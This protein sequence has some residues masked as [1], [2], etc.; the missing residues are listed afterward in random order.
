MF[1]NYLRVAL[2][3]LRRQRGYSFINVAGLTVGLACCLV[4]FQYVAFETSYDRFH[5]HEEDL[6]RVTMS[7][8]R[9]DVELG[10]GAT[11]TA[12]ATGPALAEAI[13]E[14]A[15]FT[16]VHPMHDPALVTNPAQPDVVF[17]EE[18]VLHVDPAFLEMFTFP[19]AAG[20]PR[21]ALQRGTVLISGRTARRYFGTS[22][23][24][25]E[26]LDIVGQ[27]DG[28]Y[29]VAG[30][31][32]DVP[33]NSHLQFEMLLP[34]E[35]LLE[36]GQYV[37]EPEGGW[38]FNNFI[39]YLQLHP[40][41][42]REEVSR[43]MA[44]VFVAHQGER[45]REFGFRDASM[46]AQPLRDVY[47]NADVMAFATASSSYRTVYFFTIIGLVTLLIALVNYVNLAT[48]RSLDRAREVGV[49]KAIGAQRRQLI[50]QFMAESALTIAAAALLAVALAAALMPVVNNLA[51]THLTWALWL[52]PGFWA[53]FVATLAV[54][55]L[56]A[57]LYPAF[58]LSSFQPVAVLK[59]RMS[60]AGGQ[61]WLRRGLVVFQFAAAVVLIGGTAIVYN[62]LDYMR[63]MDLGLDLEQVLTVPGPRVVAE[64]TTFTNARL[65]FVE[66]LRRIPAVR[67][68]AT[69]W[70]LPG[71]GFNHHGASTW[72][73]EHDQASS[74]QGVV[75]YVDTSFVSLYG[76][77]VIAGTDL[78][79]SHPTWGAS[80][81]SPVLA[82]ETA[83]R[84]LG[85]ASPEEALDHP[86]LIAGTE[87][88]IV[89]VLRD[90]N[91]SSAH[92]ARENIFLGRTTAGG[93]ISIR[94]G[95]AQLPATIAAIETTYTNLF[96]G[97][98]F[99]YGFVD[100]AFA[101][102]YRED[103]RFATLFSL[104]A[105]L[106]IAIAC[107]GLF[108]LATFTAQQRTKEIGVRKVMGASVPSLVALLSRDFLK[109]V[110]VAVA[111]GLPVAYLLMSRWLEGFAYR[112]ELSPG[113]FVLVATTT[114]VIALLTV[115][116]QALRAAST[117]PVKAL[118]SE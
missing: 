19:L 26:V 15:R 7:M 50:G 87:A 61:L 108:G 30:V 2:R 90:F 78:N 109:L 111:I 42:D 92:E 82:N 89:G 107:L 66:E 51:D 117:D 105:G 110:G 28:S 21:E 112:V 10:A 25:G 113:V 83:V 62:Q 14:V 56:L 36:E 47:L 29:R 58:V 49:R 3:N 11:F 74:I 54:A 44:E 32:R 100:Q 64:G 40:G 95:T 76:M 86:L 20:D 101:Q 79:E 17:E 114:L 71:Q 5:E 99:R 8:A 1:K 6:Y 38:S 33:P 43:K 22:D 27:A 57:G 35:H 53:A 68:V 81:P 72:R 96:P 118:R 31:F 94:V 12:Q 104:F 39:T 18:D 102:Q 106:A 91:W 45:L 24:I 52:D 48:A 80:P 23:P 37:D 55:T 73:A 85:F 115:S 16:R 116:Y 75:T 46:S 67:Q 59:G 13:P 98:V 65:T 93:H 97:N 70:A 77:E 34:V 84:S 88:R 63:N 69:S 41:A 60:S 103:R 9:D 4:I